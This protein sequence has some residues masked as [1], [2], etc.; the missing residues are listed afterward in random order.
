M[1]GATPEEWEKSIFSFSSVEAQERLL[2]CWVTGAAAVVADSQEDEEIL[3]KVTRLLR[4]FTGDP[5]LPPP[6]QVIRHRWSGDPLSLGGY[7]V[8]GL[9]SRQEDYSSL[10]RASPSEEEPRLLLAGEHTQPLYWSFLHG[11]R[12]AGLQQADKIIN[13][14]ATLH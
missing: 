14:L 9:S 1:E 8:P 6:D 3:E 13:H 5:A 7:S 12:L 4:M 11:A 10:M 2:V